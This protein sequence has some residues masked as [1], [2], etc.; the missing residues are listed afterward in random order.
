MSSF[1]RR[2][3]LLRGKQTNAVMIRVCFSVAVFEILQSMRDVHKR[4]AQKASWTV[5]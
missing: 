3:F 4:Q 1:L 5:P 2:S